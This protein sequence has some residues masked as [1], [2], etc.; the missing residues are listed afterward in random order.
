[1]KKFLS[2]TLVSL[3]A[4]GAG[5][6]LGLRGAGEGSA[7][8]GEEIEMQEFSNTEDKGP[9]E[10]VA[11]GAAEVSD[12]FVLIDKP[13]AEE[14]AVQGQK[15]IELTSWWGYLTPKVKNFIASWI[16]RQ[17]NWGAMNSALKQASGKSAQEWLEYLK[18]KGSAEAVKYVEERTGYKVDK[19]QEIALGYLKDLVISTA[20]AG[21][22]VLAQQTLGVNVF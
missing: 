19:L 13:T 21:G 10:G 9:G 12:D 3:F 6:F 22:N 5:S 16:P 14:M 18:A 11:Q 17:I 7:I 4:I 20:K 15:E 8:E 1:M 2:L